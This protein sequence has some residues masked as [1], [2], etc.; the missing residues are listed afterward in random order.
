MILLGLGLYFGFHALWFSSPESPGA[1]A[2]EAHHGEGHHH[3]SDTHHHEHGVYHHA[4]VITDSEICS[5]FAKEILVEGGNA[6]DAGVAAMF[7]L[8]VVHPHSSG[9][10]GVLSA[11]FYNG[12]SGTT[13]ALNALPTESLNPSIGAPMMLQGL[14]LIHQKYGKLG[15]AKL[16]R[17]PVKLAREGFPIDELLAGAMREVAVLGTDLC[18]PLCERGQAPKGVGALAINRKLAD[19]LEEL[20]QEME[21]AWFPEPLARHV[22]RDLRQDPQALAVTLK[23]QEADLAEPLAAEFDGFALT[24]PPPPAAGDVLIQLTT[25]LSQLSLSW[26]NVSN[27]AN[28]S[29]TYQAILNVAQQVYQSLLGLPRLVPGNPRNPGKGKHSPKAAPSGSHVTVVDTSG[30]ILAMLGSLN[31]T[32]GSRTLS[33]STGIF[34]SDF[35]GSRASGVLYWACPGLLSAKAGDD[36]MVILSAGGATA[37]FASAQAIVNMVYLEKSAKEAVAGPRFY[38]SVGEQGA[39]RKCVSGLRSDSQIFAR[40]SQVDPDLELVNGTAAPVTVTVVES[41]LGHKRAF[42]QPQTRAFADGY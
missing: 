40:L 18:P 5:T 39:L 2:G 23:R 14:R 28:A 3:H 6:V 16:L 7:C 26:A 35:I 9:I 34:L 8:G 11:V 30:N 17:R 37:P 15:W 13:K 27:A 29:S 12:S 20:V 19:V 33:P 38:L 41:H 36:L 31:S 21:G 10:G 1:S 25:R 32:F 4:A 22:A 24:V 42:G